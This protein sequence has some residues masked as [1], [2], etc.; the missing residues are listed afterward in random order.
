[1]NPGDRNRIVIW[2][3][4]A[5]PQEGLLQSLAGLGSTNEILGLFIEDLG[6]LELSRLPVAREFTL[7]TAATRAFEQGN[8]ER[9]FRAHGQRLQKLFE[10]AASRIGSSCSF[11]TIRGETG[12]ELV[13]VSATCDMLMVAHSRRELAPRLTLRARLEELLTSGPPALMFVQE[14]WHTGRCIAV[15]FDGSNASAA[16]LRS[17]ASHAVTENLLLSIWLPDLTD[18]GREQ[19]K[20]QCGEIIGDTARAEYRELPDQHID[21]LVRAAALSKPRVLVLPMSEP[22]TT[23]GLVTELLARIDCSLLVVR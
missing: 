19:L 3:D 23:R 5:T 10:Q 1:M 17:A 21:T 12:A 20:A 2:L 22:A 11:R 4:P 18:E 6:L 14:Q 7:D 9:Q 16:A 13:K 15:V 8:I